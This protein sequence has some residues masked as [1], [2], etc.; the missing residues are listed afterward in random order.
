LYR[1]WKVLSLMKDDAAGSQRSGNPLLRKSGVV[2]Q[3]QGAYFGLAAT[4]SFGSIG[5]VEQGVDLR[6]VSVAVLTQLVLGKDRPLHLTTK[7]PGQPWIEVRQPILV[8][9]PAVATARRPN[10]V[11]DGFANCLIVGIKC[12]SGWGHCFCAVMLHMIETVDHIIDLVLADGY[13]R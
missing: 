9:I 6:R 11:R 1:S 4:A 3:A 5:A 8:E 12:F 2:S 10:G 7:L 13:E